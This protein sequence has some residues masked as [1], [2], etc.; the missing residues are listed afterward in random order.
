MAEPTLSFGELDVLA[1]ELAFGLLDGAERASALRRQ[2]EDPAFLALV[3]AWRRRA[4]TWVDELAPEEVDEQVWSRIQLALGHAS[5]SDGASE[6]QGWRRLALLA[7][8]ACL[9]MAAVLG[10]T[11][12][13]RQNVVD[14]LNSSRQ[15]LVAIN[16]RDTN[17]AQI[18]DKHGAPL[19]SAVYYPRAG[20]LTMRVSAPETPDKAPELWVLDKAGKPHSLGLVEGSKF[21]IELSDQLRKLLVDGA[22]L[23]ITIENR[24]GAPH[25]A[26]TGDIIGTTKLSTI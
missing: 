10:V 16:Q 15:Q 11:F 13:S 22:T 2:L 17:I 26:P 12:A 19:L 3:A 24:E 9:I 21:T 5:D 4:D 6:G 20:V 1:A 8:A 23:A 25:E 14:A 7:S 18:A